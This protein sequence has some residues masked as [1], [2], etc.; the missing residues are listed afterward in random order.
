MKN[1]SDMDMSGNFIGSLGSQGNP[2]DAANVLQIA[3]LYD[4]RYAYTHKLQKVE[5]STAW[6]FNPDTFQLFAP[7]PPSPFLIHDNVS[8]V[9]IKDTNTNIPTPTNIILT[10]PNS[11]ILWNASVRIIVGSWAVLGSVQIQNLTFT[12]SA[13]QTILTTTSFDIVLPNAVFECQFL[14]DLNQWVI[15]PQK[16]ITTTSA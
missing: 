11:P 2:A 4:Q 16:V 7:S 12:C 8:V 5:F 6:V 1:L 14:S 9:T 3:L 15:I 13:A 10:L